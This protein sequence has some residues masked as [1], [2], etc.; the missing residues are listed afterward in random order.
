MI[1]VER[2]L[3]RASPLL[4]RKVAQAALVA[5]DVKIRLVYEQLR[6]RGDGYNESVKRLASRFNASHSTIKRAIRRVVADGQD[7]H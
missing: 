6:I 2:N 4:R 5:R 7:L 1:R 3:M